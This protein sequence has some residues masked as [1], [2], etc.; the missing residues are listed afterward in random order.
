MTVRS[1]NRIV[2]KISRVLCDCEAAG[3]A[4]EP[5]A[6]MADP[7]NDIV[8]DYTIRA[9]F[10]TPDVVPEF[11]Q[12]KRYCVVFEASI[13]MEQWVH[14][15]DERFKR[16]LKS[17]EKHA[18]AYRDQVREGKERVVVTANGVVNMGDI[19][20]KAEKGSVQ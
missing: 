15:S 20:R 2:D 7:G 11:D 14:F 13:T 6:T 17:L 3:I 9:C 1:I 10:F 18:I 5:I 8:G 12:T 16:N 4:V 19:K